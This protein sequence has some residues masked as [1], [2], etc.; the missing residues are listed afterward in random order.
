M[1]FFFKVYTSPIMDQSQKVFIN[2]ISQWEIVK[3]QQQSAL[4]T[5]TKNQCQ[6][7]TNKDLSKLC[8]ITKFKNK[9][10]ISKFCLF[11]IIYSNIFFLGKMEAFNRIKT[12]IIENMQDEL[13]QILDSSILPEEIAII[14]SEYSIP[15][16][17]HHLLIGNC[18]KDRTKCFTC[19]R[20]RSEGTCFA[21]TIFTNVS[22]CDHGHLEMEVP[23]PSNDDYT[24][25]YPGR[26]LINNLCYETKNDV[27]V[28]SAWKHHPNCFMS[29]IEFQ[30]HIK[31]FRHSI[32]I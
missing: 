28:L 19:F 7:K 31:K 18:K 22:Y 29:V 20:T 16:L 25:N 23:N 4:L 9:N 15:K 21:I 2:C 14:I 32:F 24:G 17:W 1:I 3:Q 30:E 5:E 8:V 26:I 6:Q 10:K 27:C 11:V 12:V 13:K